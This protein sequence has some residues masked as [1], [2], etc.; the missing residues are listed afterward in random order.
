MSK[1]IAGEEP[2]LVFIAEGALP[3]SGRAPINIKFE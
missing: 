1:G 3:L 2:L